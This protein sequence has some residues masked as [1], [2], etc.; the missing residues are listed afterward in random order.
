MAMDTSSRISAENQEMFKGKIRGPMQ[1]DP[2]VMINS[3]LNHLVLLH[4][5]FMRT[6]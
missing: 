4:S 3:D 1:E 5:M 6:R 2:C